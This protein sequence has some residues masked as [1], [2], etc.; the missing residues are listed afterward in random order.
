[1][2]KDEHTGLRHLQRLLN[3]PLISLNHEQINQ[4]PTIVNMVIL[5]LF[6][7]FA[8]D[9]L[10]SEKEGHNICDPLYFNLPA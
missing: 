4:S 5:L 6:D 1:M 2:S 10:I 7:V 9:N 3:Q 8:S